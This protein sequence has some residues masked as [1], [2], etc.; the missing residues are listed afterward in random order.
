M[1]GSTSPPPK[2]KLEKL[3]NT[4]LIRNKSKVFFRCDSISSIIALV[5]VGQSPFVEIIKTMSITSSKP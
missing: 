2:K 4:L 3:K 1:R 5:Y